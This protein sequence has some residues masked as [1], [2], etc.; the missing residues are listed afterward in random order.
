MTL[1]AAPPKLSG[2]TAQLVRARAKLATLTMW[3]ALA[4]GIL[5]ARELSPRGAAG[6]S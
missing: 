5:R 1:A 3:A 4:A 6:R 2:G